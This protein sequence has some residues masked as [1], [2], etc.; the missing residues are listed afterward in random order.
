MLRAE[1]LQTLS[2]NVHESMPLKTLLQRRHHPCKACMH[3]CARGWPA[4]HM[5]GAQ[6]SRQQH[7]CLVKK[8]C[9]PLCTQ[10]SDASQQVPPLLLWRSGL[11]ER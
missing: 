6:R 1:Q 10:N 9:T 4:S 8:A 5:C 11:Q 7:A 2:N 3:T